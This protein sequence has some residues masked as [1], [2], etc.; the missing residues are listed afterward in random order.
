M[1]RRV[2]MVAALS[3]VLLCG[4]E[5][6][7]QDEIR[8]KTNFIPVLYPQ[9]TYIP[10]GVYETLRSDPYD[11]QPVCAYGTA[12]GKPVP[13]DTRGAS[14]ELQKKLKKNVSVSADFVKG[15]SAS[16]GTDRVRDI[17]ASL[18]NV[19]IEYLDDPTVSTGLASM[20]K[21]CLDSLAARRGQ[22]NIGILQGALKADGTYQ[23]V[24]RDE[25]TL[26]VSAKQELLKNLAA[27]LQGTVSSEGQ[28]II[29]A[30]DA[31]YGVRPLQRHYPQFSDVAGPAPA[32]AT[33]A[34]Q[35]SHIETRRL[36][37]NTAST[38]GY[39]DVNCEQAKRDSMVFPFTLNAGEQVL[40]AVPG[41][42]RP[43]KVKDIGTYSH[44]LAG[45]RVTVSYYITGLDRDWK[46]DCPGGGHATF[47]VT[48]TVRVPG[49]AK[50]D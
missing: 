18:T 31:Y 17:K 11:G 28:S 38:G 22:R 6:T 8:S 33:P 35:V 19:K 45:D 27:H 32:A 15:L 39:T 9:G 42:E 34:A 36:T 30:K 49:P 10:G 3:L 23:I 4:C 43:D 44:T 12:V 47:Y 24:F 41:W 14:I 25:L 40:S 50:A 37:A 48:L 2:D 21:G 5:T 13:P 16:V 7:L 29:Q 1:R 20:S 46:R 26:D